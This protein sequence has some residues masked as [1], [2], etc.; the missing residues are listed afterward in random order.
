MN[1]DDQFDLMDDRYAEELDKEEP[2][3][4]AGWTAWRQRG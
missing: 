1:E 3:E 4:E 2:Y